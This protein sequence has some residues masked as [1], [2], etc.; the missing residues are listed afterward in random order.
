MAFQLDF[1]KYQS[2]YTPL[3]IF[4]GCLVLAAAIYGSG[5]ITITIGGQKADKGPEVAGEETSLDDFAKCLTEKGVKLYTADWCPHCAR[6][7]ELFGSAL[8]Y[9]DHTVCSKEQTD[10]WS[11]VCTQAKITGVPTWVFADKTQAQGF[12]ELEVLSKKTGC[13]LP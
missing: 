11:E 8:Q 2:L 10:P 1:R 7:K 3:A 4:V 6:Q 9:L 5:G 12:T 13:P